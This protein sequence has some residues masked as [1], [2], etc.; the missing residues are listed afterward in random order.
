[1]MTNKS[2]KF[3]H[4]AGEKRHCQITSCPLNV[5]IMFENIREENAKRKIK[6]KT[7]TE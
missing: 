7:K 4:S 6:Q 5:L 2:L 3:K 1:M